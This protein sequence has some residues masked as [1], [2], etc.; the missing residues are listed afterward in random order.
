M[1]LMSRVLVENYEPLMSLLMYSISLL[2][3]RGLF[4]EA[5]WCQ[6]TTDPSPAQTRPESWSHYA[7]AR[8]SFWM[9]VKTGLSPEQIQQT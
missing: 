3:E 7:V 9:L 4:L 8:P 2:A 6:R 1:H 5:G